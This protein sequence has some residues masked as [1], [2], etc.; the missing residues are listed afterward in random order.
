[1]CVNHGMYVEAENKSMYEEPVLFW[2]RTQ[3]VRLVSK[4]L[5]LLGQFPHH[6]I[7]S[8]TECLV[9]YYSRPDSFNPSLSRS[10]VP[11][12]EEIRGCRMGNE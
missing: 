7:T 5:Y 3:L 8:V 9:H 1:M 6:L 11:R 4:S 10:H 2:E 12:P